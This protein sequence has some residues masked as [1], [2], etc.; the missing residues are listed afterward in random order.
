MQILNQIQQD[1]EAHLKD[2]LFENDPE[3]LYAPINYILQIGGKRLR[4][5]VLLLTCYLFKGKYKHALPAALAIEVFHN[6]TLVHD[7]IMDNAPLRR[8]MP[9]VHEKYDINTGILSG[10][11]M[12]VH[13]FDLLLKLEDQKHFPT[14]LK[15]FTKLAV[16][17]C[18]GQQMDM[19]FEKQQE[20]KIDEYLRMIELKTSVLVA[21][22]MKMGALLGGADLEDAEAAYQFGRNLGISFQ[23]Q[24]DLLDTYG[25][26]EKFGKKVGGDIV[27]NKKTFL[28]LKALELADQN[29]KSRLYE[30]YQENQ[31]NEKEKIEK[32]VQIFNQIGIKEE[33]ELIKEEYKNNAFSFLRKL[34]IEE[35]RRNLLEKFAYYL[36]KR[37][38]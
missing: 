31:L 23:L 17:V 20:V 29:Q 32:V 3:E 18:E 37:D 34:N 8:G 24:D 11:V 4:P 7:D 9:T 14:L 19:N 13:A 26:P 33:T 15:I 21:G 12:M 22:A 5:A 28:Y 6:F 30:L 1:F 16:E 27:Q 36:M 35:D 2:S 25:D 38:V 10:D